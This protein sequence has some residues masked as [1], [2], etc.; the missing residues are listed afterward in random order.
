V[1]YSVS[2][3]IALATAVY[4]ENYDG[5]PGSAEQ[6]LYRANEEHHGLQPQQAHRHSQGRG[7]AGG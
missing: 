2:Q 7:P 1:L 6:Q 5:L 3:P 4:L